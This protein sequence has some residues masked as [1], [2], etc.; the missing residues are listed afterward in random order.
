MR[1]L[2][3]PDPGADADAGRD[4]RT[5]RDEHA[6]R[7]DGTSARVLA[8]AVE[9]PASAL[10]HAKGL[11]FRRELPEDYA[12]VMDVGGGDFPLLGGPRWTV[13]DMLFVHVPLDVLWLVEG[14]VVGTKRLRPWTGVGAGTADTI[15]ELPAGAASGVAVGD[16]VR[17]VGVEDGPEGGH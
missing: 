10:A 3:E 9:R 15:V 5:E 11:R 1:V 4:Q 7:R 16:T 13:V 12:F 8:A 14:E 6:R 2:H 17:V